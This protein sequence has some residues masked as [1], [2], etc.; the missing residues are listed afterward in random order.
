MA[1][2]TGSS[3]QNSSFFACFVKYFFEQKAIP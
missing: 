3:A 1:G 2:S